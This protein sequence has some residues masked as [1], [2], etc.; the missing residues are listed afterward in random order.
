M[1]REYS[2]EISKAPLARGDAAGLWITEPSQVEILNTS[3]VQPLRKRRLR[4][5]RLSGDGYVANI[6]QKRNA[7]AP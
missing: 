6:D 3:F 2:S 5:T 1:G 4:E 7:I